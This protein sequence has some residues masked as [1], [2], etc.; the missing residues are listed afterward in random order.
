MPHLILGLRHFARSLARVVILLS[1][2]LAL[3][4]APDKKGNEDTQRCKLACENPQLC[5]KL[6]AILDKSPLPHARL[7][8]L[9]QRVGQAKPLA[10]CAPDLPLN[11]ASNTKLWTTAAALT[12]LG[13]HYRY[14]T[15]LYYHTDKIKD[16]VLKGDLYVQS[17]L[18]P[19]LVTGEV[20]EMAQTLYARGL[21]A[22]QGR[23]VFVSTGKHRKA[24]P[25]GFG[26][27]DELRS[28]RTAIGSPS[29][30]YNT[31]VVWVTPGPKRGAPATVA[32]VPPTTGLS[33]DNLSTTTRGSA[34][35][36]QISL[37]RG[38][39][40]TLS[41]RVAG[42]VGERASERSTRLPRYDPTQYANE[43]F[44]QALL[45]AGITISKSPFK[46]AALPDSA[47][48][49]L[50]HDSRPISELIRSVN[51]FSNNFMA[52][53]ILWSMTG[54]N[55][56]PEA[57]LSVLM[58]F[59]K[60]LKTPAKDLHFGN[61]SGLYQS[62]TMSAR[63]LVHL[64]Q[65]TATDFRVA[66]DFLASLSVMGQDGTTRRRL[67][68]SPAAGW[69]RAKTGTLDGVSALSGYVSAPG[70]R[71]IVFSILINDFKS[72]EIGHARRRQDEIVVALYELLATPS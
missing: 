36:A 5:E 9:A 55:D 14:P 39:K 59:A 11:P 4:P 10:Q 53:Q 52:E 22:I 37:V 34:N 63:Q 61:G 62:N 2:S 7:S 15:R 38:K 69:V 56:P 51:K 12:R 23:I 33:V 70:K 58:D 50:R 48:L 64:L 13:P 25:P 68:N 72:W 26:Q 35:R 71:A 65:K 47:S 54:P 41:I 19:A 66:S 21:R 43:V 44:Q 3:A 1:L 30:N 24:M 42:K 57:G 31:F 20:F 67:R 40:K 49:V 29:V 46:L 32:I 18:D 16:G 17:D 6:Q 8:F 27:K 60:E 28:Y 45:A